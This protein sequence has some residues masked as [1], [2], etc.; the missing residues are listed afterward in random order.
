[1]AQGRRALAAARKGLGTAARI[2]KAK[3]GGALLHA[4]RGARIAGH[5][6]RN[7]LQIVRVHGGRSALAMRDAGSRFWNFITSPDNR[8]AGDIFVS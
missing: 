6:S 3:L 8:V 2:G 5:H 1:M 7:G 4:E